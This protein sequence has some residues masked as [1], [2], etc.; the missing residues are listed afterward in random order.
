MGA[1]YSCCLCCGGGKEPPSLD[2]VGVWESDD[3]NATLIMSAAG[4][5]HYR[6]T[7]GNDVEGVISTWN[8]KLTHTGGFTFNVIPCCLCCEC[9]GYTEFDC[10][11]PPQFGTGQLVRAESG[12]YQAKEAWRMIVNEH[13]FIRSE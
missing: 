4:K 12:Q 10:S 5:V 8:V 1:C 7:S 11:K 9:C 3:K 13:R 6:T 2:W